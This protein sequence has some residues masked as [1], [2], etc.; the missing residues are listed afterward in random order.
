MG[1]WFGRILTFEVVA[2]SAAVPVAEILSDAADGDVLSDTD[3]SVIG[4]AAYGASVRAAIEPLVSCFAIDL[5]DDG[6]QLRSPSD[7]GAIVL[8][9][10]ISSA[11]ARTNNKRPESNA[12]RAR[13]PRFRPCCDYLTM[14][15]PETI[16]RG[17]P[18]HRPRT[19]AAASRGWS[20]RQCWQPTMQ[21]LSF[22][23]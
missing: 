17:R 23:R 19:R 10:E 4:Y 14:T 6:L 9:E 5:F 2:D 11:T 7:A 1:W 20:F 15:R 16:S 12:S 21:S 8:S 13:S 18:G 3:H 22:I